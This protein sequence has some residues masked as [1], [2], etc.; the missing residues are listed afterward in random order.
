MGGQRPWIHADGIAYDRIHDVLYFQALTGRT[1]YQISAVMLRNEDLDER[2]LAEKVIKTAAT[3]P[4][5]GLIMDG[6]S[7]LYLSNLEDGA[8]DRLTTGTDNPIITRLFQSPLIEWPD[9]F[10]LTADGWLYVAT[11][12]IHKG[13]NPS[14]PYRVLR[15]PVEAAEAIQ[16]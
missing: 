15:F 1:L 12:Q 2:S 6:K 5:D 16:P 4:V 14:E 9:S 13:D 7:R 11:S 10:S 3:F 8:I